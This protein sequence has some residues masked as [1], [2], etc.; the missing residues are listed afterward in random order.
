MGAI[1]KAP[2]CQ[3]CHSGQV[4]LRRLVASDGTSR[5]SWWC[6]TCERWAQNPVTWIAHSLVKAEL[7]RWK[8]SIEDIQVVGD[9]SEQTPCVICGKPGQWHHW[10]PQAMSERFGE[11]WFKWPCAYLCEYHHQLWH[12]IVTPSLTSWKM[13]V[14]TI[15]ERG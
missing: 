8:A 11:D 13:P 6:L 1:L 10:A 5:I 14:R 9:Y 7:S 12:C 2:P 3:H 4:K 15:K